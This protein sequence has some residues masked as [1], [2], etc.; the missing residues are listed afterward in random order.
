M[1]HDY[2][3]DFLD[4][5]LNNY[6]WPAF[7]IADSAICVGAVILIVMSVGAKNISPKK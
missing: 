6:H 2:V 1:I 5:H 3:V 4:V 7:N